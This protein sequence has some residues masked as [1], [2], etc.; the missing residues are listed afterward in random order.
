MDTFR[1]CGDEFAADFR[2]ERGIAFTLS[3]SDSTASSLAMVQ[4]CG[5]K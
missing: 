5:W 4:K 2:F 1:I 3:L